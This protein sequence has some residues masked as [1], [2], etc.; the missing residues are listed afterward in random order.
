M[1]CLAAQNLA[2]SHGLHLHIAYSGGSE[3]TVTDRTDTAIGDL[4]GGALRQISSIAGSTDAR[5]R[6]GQ[7]GSYGE[8]IIIR[9]NNSVIKFV[10]GLCRRH[11]HQRGA[12][13]TGIAVGRTVYH[14][15]FVCALFLGDKGRGTAAVQIHRYHASGIQHDLS[16][17][18]GAAAS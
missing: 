10:G 4:Q 5:D 13:G 12:D 9:R 17:L 1:E 7:A 18:D 14:R 11:Y 2:V 3:C 16:D 15:Q 8:I 6:D